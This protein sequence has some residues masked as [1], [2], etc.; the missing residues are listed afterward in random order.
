MIS[1]E[2]TRCR[3]CQSALRNALPTQVELTAKRFKSIMVVGWLMFYIGIGLGVW[4]LNDYLTTHPLTSFFMPMGQVT[5]GV[6]DAR[7]MGMLD[8]SRTHPNPTRQP[9]AF[10]FTDI[11]DDEPILKTALSLVLS[12]FL[13]YRIGRGLAWWNNG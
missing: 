9:P 7:F 8:P 11:F 4:G 6:M 3:Y 10:Q 5:T 12:G 13:L 2:A 1:A